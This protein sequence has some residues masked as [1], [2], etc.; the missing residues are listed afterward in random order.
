MGSRCSPAHSVTSKVIFYPGQIAFALTILLWIAAFGVLQSTQL[1]AQT[2]SATPTLR[3][4]S[5][6]TLV[7]VIAE[8]KVKGLRTREL[9][10]NLQ[11]EDFRILDNRREMQI[12]SFDIGV[13]HTA[14]PIALWLIVQC[15]DG[16]PPGHHS[17]FMRGKTKFLKAALGRLA[18]NDLIGV[19]HWCDNGDATLDLPAGHDPEMAL[20]KVEDIL[21]E[22]P[23]TG[24]QTRAGELAMQRMIRLVLKDTNERVTQREPILLFLYGDR[25]GT[26]VDEADSIATD[27]LETS[28][29]VYGMNDGTWYS[30]TGTNQAGPPSIFSADPPGITST[31]PIGPRLGMTRHLVHYYSGET[32]GEVYSTLDPKQF[33]DT[34]DALLTKLHLRYTIGFTPLKLDGKRH[35]LTVELTPVA[36]KRFPGAEL[37]FRSEYIPLANR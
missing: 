21:N 1:H 31:S 13:E 14:R 3:V 22:K 7:D 29:V 12:K 25:S 15:N 5:S 28:A 19:A 24:T 10:P 6:L 32:G 20:S 9:L 30:A 34:L 4:E 26:H 36:R 23:T 11:R 27:L 16:E 17:M 18:E 2:G 8:N 35:S 37:R 33:S